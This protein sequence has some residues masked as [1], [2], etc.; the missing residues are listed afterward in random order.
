M[1]ELIDVDVEISRLQKEIERLQ[2]INKGIKAKLEN[3][4]FVAKAPEKVVN[5]EKEKLTNN[6]DK[7]TKLNENLKRL[8]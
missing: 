4:N 6:Q 5:G 8:I 3:Q 1:A 2:S 7:L